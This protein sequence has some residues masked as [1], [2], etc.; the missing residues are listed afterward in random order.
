MATRGANGVR[1]TLTPPGGAGI[2]SVTVRTTLWSAC[3]FTGDGESDRA[4]WTIWRLTEFDVCDWPGLTVSGL[5]T[6]TGNPPRFERSTARRST[7]SFV[8]LTKCVTRSTPLNWTIE[9]D[10]K[11][12]PLTVRLCAPLPATAT[13]G[14]IEPTTGV[15]TLT[16]K[17]TDPDAATPAGVVTVNVRDPVG[18]AGSI[19]ICTGRLVAV[20][21]G[22][23]DAWTPVL[24]KTTDEA[25]R[26]LVPP[27][28]AFTTAPRL[29]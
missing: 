7:V 27:M 13:L 4:G 19:V 28:A 6:R 11:F 8:A 25:P 17:T 1:V 14:E 26:R 20:P 29:P 21:P 24:E 9:S 16:V 5:T 15:A 3:T 23:I 2:D 18:A 22:W 12:A 10:W